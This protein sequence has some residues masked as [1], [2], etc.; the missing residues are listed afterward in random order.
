MRGSTQQLA[1]ED[2]SYQRIILNRS[3]GDVLVD[4]NRRP[5]VDA[6]DNITGNGTVINVECTSDNA[7]PQHQKPLLRLSSNLSSPPIE[8]RERSSDIGD[9][10]SRTGSPDVLIPR[11]DEPYRQET[12]IDTHTWSKT[13]RH[14]VKNTGEGKRVLTEEERIAERNRKGRE[15]SMRTRRRNANRLK[16]LQENCAYLHAENGFLRQ[17]IFSIRENH[18]WPTVF[19]LVA[20]MASLRSGRPPSYV[21]ASKEAKDVAYRGLRS[22]FTQNTRTIQASQV[23]VMQSNSVTETSLLGLTISDAAGIPGDREDSR[24]TNG[25]GNAED[26]RE[27]HRNDFGDLLGWLAGGSRPLN[28]E[29]VRGSMQH[30]EEL[31]RIS[32]EEIADLVGNTD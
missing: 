21:F 3:A 31:P 16:N 22:I 19:S 15:R 27:T 13:Q 8:N 28:G 20:K 18:D 4:G 12:D 17:I 10:L 1:L 29:E 30:L 2:K 11:S 6:G 14:N 25:Q 26:A 23:P 24:S 7:Y 9:T 5:S 32:F